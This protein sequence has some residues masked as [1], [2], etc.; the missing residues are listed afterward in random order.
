[1]VKVACVER[2]GATDI[3]ANRRVSEF[4][5]EHISLSDTIIE[6]DVL[7]GVAKI[8]EYMSKLGFDMTPRRCFDWVASGR[9]PHTKVGVQI[10]STRSAIR[11]RFLDAIK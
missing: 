9:I 8:A 10:I 5:K 7:H 11:E 2:A 3:K 6:N 4:Q 1:L